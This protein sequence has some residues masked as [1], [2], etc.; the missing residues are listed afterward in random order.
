[1]IGSSVKKVKTVGI[2]LLLVSHLATSAGHNPL[3][4]AG[5][6]I[7]PYWIDLSLSFLIYDKNGLKQVHFNV[8]Y[9]LKYDD[10]LMCYTAPTL[11]FISPKRWFNQNCITLANLTPAPQ[12]THAHTRM[13]AHIHI[14]TH[15][16]IM[17]TPYLWVS[18]TYEPSLGSLSR[19]Y[20]WVVLGVN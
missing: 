19:G 13:R 10:L 8:I 17:H 7:N 6:S 18:I 5:K 2:L 12:N 20:P 3:H 15:V 1:M 16:H 11:I 14:I 9:I 4:T